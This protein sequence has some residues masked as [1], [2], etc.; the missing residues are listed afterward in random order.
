M[1]V[2]AAKEGIMYVGTLRWGEDLFDALSGSVADQM[3]LDLHVTPA[4]VVL[5]ILQWIDSDIV[6]QWII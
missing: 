6:K 4:K 2:V 3:V 1:R 5:S